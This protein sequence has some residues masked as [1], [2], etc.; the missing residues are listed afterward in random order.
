M[1]ADDKALL[2]NRL[3]GLTTRLGLVGTSVHKAL[4]WAILA[5]D[6]PNRERYA[7]TIARLAEL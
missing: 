4:K 6:N 3:Q 1:I 5:A 2:I 7:V